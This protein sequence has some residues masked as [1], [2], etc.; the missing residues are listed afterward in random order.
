MNCGI[1]RICSLILGVCVSGWKENEDGVIWETQDVVRSDF[2]F[3]MVLEKMGCRRLKLSLFLA[4]LMVIIY[5][6]IENGKLKDYHADTER[7]VKQVLNDRLLFPDTQFSVLD[8]KGSDGMSEEEKEVLENRIAELEEDEE[9]S[10]DEVYKEEAREEEAEGRWKVGQ[11][12]EEEEEGRGGGAHVQALVEGMGSLTSTHSGNNSN[13]IPRHSNQGDAVHQEA[14][15]TPDAVPNI[16]T[17]ETNN[18]KNRG[19]DADPWIRTGKH[20]HR[21]KGKKKAQ[22]PGNQINKVSSQNHEPLANNGTK[23]VASNSF[24]SLPREY[25]VHINER[26]Q[27]EFP[28]LD[29]CT[30]SKGEEE[31]KESGSVQA[32][33]APY[34][35]RKWR[36]IGNNTFWPAIVDPTNGKVL[37]TLDLTHHNPKVR[38]CY[39]ILDALKCGVCVY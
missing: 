5:V 22:V 38:L 30:S 35:C 29:H 14:R 36:D 33:V 18:G 23:I 3:L 9:E 27:V 20:K 13:G 17:T 24:I 8:G 16:Q 7:K 21:D 25:K 15:V 39:I 34:P 37:N 11:S 6:H 28:S 31:E 10:D 4:V 32:K 12:L 26:G 19:K 2:S 1:Y